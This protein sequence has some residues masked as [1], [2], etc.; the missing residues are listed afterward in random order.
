[1]DAT[2]FILRPSA[3]IS[4][5]H[6]LYPEGSTAGYL[7]ID[8]EVSDEDSTYIFVK[9]LTD[10]SL[11]LEDT[12]VTATS[13]FRLSGNVPNDEIT[14]TNIDLVYSAMYSAYGTKTSSYTL[15]VNG[16][17]IDTAS[18][19]N[20][21]YSYDAKTITLG[22]DV[23]DYINNYIML[24]GG[25]PEITI[26]IQ[27]SA[28]SSENDKG[29][30]VGYVYLSQL[31]LN[32][33]YNTGVYR[34]ILDT[35]KPSYQ[36][37]QKINN[38]W[39]RVTSSN[40]K[41]I[42]RSNLLKTGHE[43]VAINGVS[44]TCTETGLTTGYRCSICGETLVAQTVIPAT[45][46]SSVVVKGYAENCGVN[47]LTDGQK[48]SVC[49]TTLVAQTT[50]PA[51]G[52]HDYVPSGGHTV[53]GVCGHVESRGFVTL[54]YNGTATEL[55]DLVAG[56]TGVSFG[57]YALFAG[58][59]VYLA[60]Y[61][62][63]I[64]AYDKSL[65]KTN[66][67]VLSTAKHYMTSTTIGNYV[68]FAGGYDKSS[69]GSLY[70]LDTIDVYDQSFTRTNPAVL[71]VSR[72]AL[73]SA[74]IGDYA[75]FAGGY[76]YQGGSNTCSTVDAYNQSFTRTNPAVLSVSRLMMAS[77]IIG[78]YALFAGGNT[79]GTSGG[80]AGLVS[81]VDA[82]NKSLTRTNPTSLNEVKY[83]FAGT[84]V[85]YYAIFAGGYDSDSNGTGTV[86]AYNK[87]LTRISA[88][89]LDV[90]RMKLSS[91]TIANI[92][93]FAGGSEDINR[94]ECSTVDAYDQSLTRTN[95]TGLSTARKSLAA[96]R[97]GDYA[98]FAGGEPSSGDKFNI[99]D[100]YKIN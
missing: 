3:D 12:T 8:E 61:C 80:T 82:Y 81:T 70:G 50:I 16:I 58:G 65:T 43:Q 91:T 98:L 5:G 90:A 42:M 32:V 28:T 46:H 62:D 97:V 63:T 79:K 49:G 55:T 15:I 26:S 37:Y 18:L 92:A 99:V 31:Y 41:A 68:L 86:D 1:M 93:L 24:N 53:C 40:A 22:S 2:T 59:T 87:S 76:N 38:V 25:F 71:S 69:K 10:D 74:T 30:Q 56:H 72:Y 21:M 84:S 75:L 54:S 36:L 45:G 51:T 6:S 96:A 27:S 39:T 57:N 100:V 33:T 35:W 95:P 77:T 89:R 34:K 66:P 48:C 85:G 20:T 52:N 60:D 23:V 19:P 83:D 13:S 17:S 44:P 64:N 14:V 78:D 47:G 67:A 4:V 94:N 73:T 9:S 88:Y 11:A 7:L 29:K